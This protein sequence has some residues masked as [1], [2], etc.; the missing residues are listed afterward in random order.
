M[1]PALEGDPECTVLLAQ[2]M[3]THHGVPLRQGEVGFL[4]EVRTSENQSEDSPNL[5]P[6][7]AQS[8]ASPVSQHVTPWHPGTRGSGAGWTCQG[9]PSLPSQRVQLL[10]DRS[11]WG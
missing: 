9:L 5:E 3:G 2:E 1:D 6:R 7:E 11:C 8:A 10:R 4:C